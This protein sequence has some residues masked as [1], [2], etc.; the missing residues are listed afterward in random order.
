MPSN[1]Y[2]I[3]I[4]EYPH[5]IFSRQQFENNE[6]STGIDVP[7]I[8]PPLRTNLTLLR[9]S[10]WEYDSSV[11]EYP[12]PEPPPEV[13]SLDVPCP[14]I[15][16]ELNLSWNGQSSWVDE[17]G[18][19]YVQEVKPGH[20]NGLLIRKDAMVSMLNSRDMA[21]VLLIHQE[22]MVVGDDTN[23]ERSGVATQHTVACLTVNDFKI[24]GT[25]LKN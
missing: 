1:N 23:S 15:I 2:R 17:S 8:E 18:D 19:V 12:T 3:Y 6:V 7:G 13:P 11:K 5:H 16:K 14:E 25:I 24:L 21:L 9:G 20:S 4:R 10:E 22:K